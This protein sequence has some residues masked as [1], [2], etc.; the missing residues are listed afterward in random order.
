VSQELSGSWSRRLGYFAATIFIVASASQNA[1]HGWQLGLRTSEITATIFAA[2]SVAGAIMAPIALAAS[3]SAFRRC[4]LVRGVVALALAAMCFAYAT[5][6]SLGFVSG[7]RDVAAATR[8]AEADTYAIARDKAKAANA[9]LKTLAEAPRGTRKIEKERAERK[10]KLEDDR[11]DAERVMSEGA[12]A[13]VADPTA[14]AIA[15]YAGAL[16]YDLEPTKLSP[17][18]S[19]FAVVFFEAGAAFSLIVVGAPTRAA[20]KA[21]P[22]KAAEAKSPEP[23]AAPAMAAAP[24]A[25]L[26]DNKKTAG[27][28][29]SRALDDVLAKIEGAGGKLEGTLDELGERLGL[30]KSSAH[31]A[32]HALAGAGMISL[33]TSA[34]GTLI[35]TKAMT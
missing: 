12:T 27:R 1:L 26:A 15:S 16:G 6:S 5:V 8:G 4:Q 17:W 30:S 32:L 2:A 7:A 18:L 10:A 11:A 24:E 23:V 33:A 19:L 28:K 14:A 35:Q 22:A 31:R 20:A 34:A 9:E 25:R 29:R 13:T 3:F 21:E